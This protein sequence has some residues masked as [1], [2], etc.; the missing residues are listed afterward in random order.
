MTTN[1]TIIGYV[2]I[3]ML[4]SANIQANEEAE[5]FR[6]LYSASIKRAL[7]TPDREDDLNLAD[8]MLA[9]AKESIGT[10]TML[11]LMCT[12]VYKLTSTNPAGYEK[13]AEAMELLAR[14]VPKQSVEALEKAISLRQRLYAGSRGDARQKAGDALVDVLVRIAIAKQDIGDTRGAISSWRRAQQIAMQ[15]ESDRMSELEA[16]FKN[17]LS[18]RR[19]GDRIAELRKTLENHPND[20]K[21]ARQLVEVIVIELDRPSSAIQYSLQTADKELNR[22]V[23]LATSD[24]TSISKTDSLALGD[25]YRS[26]SAKTT[27]PKSKSAM[28]S[29]AKAYYERFIN[30]NDAN[31]LFT[32]KAQ[33]AVKG[34]DASLAK[35]ESTGVETDSRSAMG[36]RIT[37]SVGMKLM[38][39]KPGSFLMG[40]PDD[41]DGRNADEVRHPVKITKGYYMG[42]ITVTQAQ[43]KAVVG[44]T[45]W[46]GFS[47]TM[48]GDSDEFPA[49]GITWVD[50][51]AFCKKLSEK[52]K[53]K[54]R[55][56]TEAEWE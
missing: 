45:P 49:V 14:H 21:T 16:G 19:T 32:K 40:S 6:S 37:N 53:R 23:M 39:I 33:L 51:V 2:I 31:D 35:L 4:Y 18:L 1:N 24:I 13:A 20:Q 41:E 54:Y 15:I 30:L 10:P 28:F 36:K 42:A 34:I 44:T 50:A 56:P 55:L 9:A 29:R 43:W 3:A 47:T 48:R 46:S 17:A 26:L 11:S 5:V 8:T 27:Q 12:H 25:W 22:L 52:E 7:E 38:Y